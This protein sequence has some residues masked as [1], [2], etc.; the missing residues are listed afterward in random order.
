ML[1]HNANTGILVSAIIFLTYTC[2][3]YRT[4]FEVFFFGDVFSIFPPCFF[5]IDYPLTQ[6]K[7]V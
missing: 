1:V 5:D 3:K 4:S 7:G 6:Y 2:G